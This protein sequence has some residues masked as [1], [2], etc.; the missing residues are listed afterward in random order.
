MIERKHLSL[1]EDKLNHFSA[2]GLLG[3]RQIGKTTL[4][5]QI[6]SRRPSLYLDLENYQDLRK[7]ED[8]ISYFESHNDKLI[9]L[10]EIHRKPKIFMTLRGLIDKGRQQ[11]RK[12]GQFLILGSATLDLLR[13]ASESL[14]GRITYI[15]MSPLNAIEIPST[16]KDSQRLWIQGGFPDSFL[17][18]TP[19][20]SLEW[21]HAFIKTYLERNI[22]QFGPRI[23][24]ETLHRLWTM[25]AH[26]QGTLLNSTK[27]AA[28]LGISGQT[29]SRYIDLLTDLFLLRQ[30]Q[31]WHKNTGKRLVRSPKIYVRDSGILHALL[32]INSLD[33]LLSHPVL[34]TSWEGFAIDN[35]LSFLPTGSKSYFYCTSRGAEIDLIIE[36]PDE[37]LLAIEI[38]KS[39]APKL[40]HGFI[41]VCKDINPTHRYVVYDGDEKFSLGQDVKAISLIG[42][43]HEILGTREK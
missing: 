43:I 36:L 18:P 13:Q 5:L 2:V 23:P 25:L 29:V 3:P 17:A 10:D 4:A 33:N 11:G 34:G 8:P 28:G 22:P 39:S 41:E 19:Q 16:S 27:L 12:F 40:E 24:A 7:L 1:V 30:L 42:L 37:R 15:D 31:P 26:S 6:A 20:A 14:A 32:N 21:R 38:K 35:L 9:I